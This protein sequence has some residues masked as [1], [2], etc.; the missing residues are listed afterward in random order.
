MFVSFLF[1][2]V[3]VSALHFPMFGEVDLL[4]GVFILIHPGPKWDWHFSAHGEGDRL[5][6]CAGDL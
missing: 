4:L 6:P 2:G 5:N 3:G 1:D